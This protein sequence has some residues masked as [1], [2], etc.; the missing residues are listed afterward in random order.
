MVVAK[1]FIG[2]YLCQHFYEFLF[3]VVDGA[4][5]LIV[6]LEDLHPVAIGIPLVIV[7]DMLVQAFLQ[8]P[9]LSQHLAV[10]GLADPPRDS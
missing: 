6:E 1:P 9:Q 8:M 4:Q 7:G 5:E 3:G 2:V 10:N